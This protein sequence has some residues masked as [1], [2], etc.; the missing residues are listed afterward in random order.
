MAPHGSRGLGGKR[1]SLLEAPALGP[2]S[3]GPGFLEGTAGVEEG[4]L[5]LV[6]PVGGT[7]LLPST[8]QASRGSAGT[9]T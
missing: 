2:W 4:L 8:V 5:V 9:S 1:E 7:I 6:G 3:Q